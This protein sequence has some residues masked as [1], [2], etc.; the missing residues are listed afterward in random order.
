M[1]MFLRFHD[2]MVLVPDDGA[3]KFVCVVILKHNG[4]RFLLFF[5]SPGF[6]FLSDSFAFRKSSTSESK[7]SPSR[8]SFTHQGSGKLTMALSTLI[9]TQAPLTNN[10][11][12][13]PRPCEAGISASFV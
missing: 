8:P 5:T 1:Y 7:G 12:Y 9:L 4:A 2:D 13:Y 6:S 11:P 3:Q 10:R